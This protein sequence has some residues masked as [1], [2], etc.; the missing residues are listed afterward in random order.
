MCTVRRGVRTAAARLR[1]VLLQ[2]YWWIPRPREGGR[3]GGCATWSGGVAH[4]IAG[5]DFLRKPKWF[6]RGTGCLGEDV[7]TATRRMAEE[8]TCFH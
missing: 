7:Q 2:L 6:V 3:G 1:L 4:P 5:C 8:P